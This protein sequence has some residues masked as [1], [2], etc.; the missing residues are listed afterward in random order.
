MTLSQAAALSCW[1]R[2]QPAVQAGLPRRRG[3]QPGAEERRPLG[4]GVEAEQRL[5]PGGR[6]VLARSWKAQRRSWAVLA[7]RSQGEPWLL[8]GPRDVDSPAQQ[9]SGTLKPDRLGV[10]DPVSPAGL[11]QVL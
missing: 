9:G 4:W 8:H 5:E 2:G 7:S 11:Q 6:R 3:A 10:G 1:G